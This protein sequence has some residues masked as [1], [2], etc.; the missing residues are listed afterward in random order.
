MLYS[1]LKLYRPVPSMLIPAVPQG[2][3]VCLGFFGENVNFLDVYRRLGIKTS[4]VKYVFEP[5]ITGVAS[6]RLT[7]EYKKTLR[8][9]KLLPVTGP[10]GDYSDLD[11]K[12]FFLDY[13]YPLQRVL[14]RYQ[15][16]NYR[17]PVSARRVLPLLN[18]LVGVP[19]S[20][21]E[22]V[23]L[24][25]VSIDETISPI[26]MKR[27][28]YIIYQLLMEWF[29]NPSSVKLP[30]DK[31]VMFMY[32][33]TE[34]GRYVLIFDKDSKLNKLARIKAILMNM[35]MED[36][37][38]EE[39]LAI[40]D[41]SQDVSQNNTLLDT[42]DD[43]MVDKTRRIVQTFINNSPSLSGFSDTKPPD[44][45][46]QGMD[47]S[48]TPEA[49]KKKNVLLTTAILSHTMGDPHKASKVAKRMEAMTTTDQSKIVSNALTYAL[50]RYDS[51]SSSRNPV[52]TMSNP[53]KMTDN[54]NPEHIL[55]KRKTDFKETLTD[56]LLD[57]FK[58]LKTKHLPLQV[59]S[60]K[61]TTVSSPPSE[62]KPTLKDR[63]AVKLTDYEN[64]VHDVLVELPHLTENGTFIVNGQQ[65]VLIN[66]L[67]VYP[68]FF[69]KP[70]SGKFT[71]SYSTV[72]IYSKILRK[73]SYLMLFM[74][75][76]KCPL[77]MY[78]SYRE[79]FEYTLKR[80][81]VE[82][83]ITEEKVDSS[84]L[85]PN[86]KY[87]SFTAKDE[88]GQQLAASFF[89]S[90]ASL[91]KEHF[92][93][94][95][96]KYWKSVLETFVGNRNCTYL[97][98]QVWQN[99]VTPIEI[100]L[101]ESRGDPTNI[102]DI[103]KYISGQV[104]HGR[105]DDRNTL[106]RQ[107]IR[108]S[109]IFVS[110][111]QKQ[112]LAAYNEYEAKREA[113]DKN[114]RLYINSTKTFSEVINSQNVQSLENINP[115]EELSS[116]TRVTPI[117]VGGIPNVEAYP[118]RAL[119][120]H[121]TYFGNIDP[122]ETPDGPNVGVQQQLAIG[123]N[124]T[125]VRG[126]FMHRDRSKIKPTEMLSTGPSMIP[127]V[128]SNEGARVTMATGQAKQAVP[129]QNP[130]V[131]C[132]QSGYESILTPLLSDAF[133][134]KAD[135]TGTIVEIND[136]II[137][138]EDSETK[139]RHAI[140]VT[141]ITLKSGQ[142]KNGLSAFKPIVSLG[143]KV[144]KGQV[145]AEGAN[146]KDGLISNGLN[147]LVA[148]MP[149]KGY[150][151]EDGMVISESAA[152]KFVSLHVE[153]QTVL[154]EEGEDVVFIAPT[155]TEIAKGSILVAYSS[156]IHDVESHK[157]LRSDGG[158]VVEVEVYSNLPEEQIPEK[159][160]PIYEDFKNRYIK[161]KGSYPIGQF[162]EKD[163]KIK[164]ILI[165]YTMQQALSLA[166]GDKLN[167]RHFNKGVVSIIEKDENMPRTPWG[168]HV[169]MVY[170]PL[171]VINRMI[172]GQILETHC[173]LIAKKLGEIITTKSRPEF[174]SLL[175]TVIDLLDGTPG[176]VYS[177]SLTKNILALSDKGYNNLIEKTKKDKFFPLIFVPFKSP[178]RN[179]IEKALSLCGLKPR[180]P[181]YLKEFDITTGP[182]AV[183]YV[184][185]LK[186]EHMSE[187]KIHARGVGPYM[188]G[189]MAPT[190]GKKRSGG[191]QLGEY[192]MYSLLGWDCPT[193]VDEFFGPSSSDH[194][195]KNQ[196]ISE[197]I[198]TG[199][200]TFRQ[201]KTNPVKDLFTHTMLAIHL[202][203]D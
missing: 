146:I 69:F 178:E 40:D 75:G 67:I 124:I 107:R 90:L 5:M 77:I 89:Y 102:S 187:K 52:T 165:K 20:N 99:V 172:T 110:L 73:A 31:I 36:Y 58:V 34:P 149:W 78:L 156:A 119:N 97:M 151:F 185:V 189:T 129:L 152:K 182:V 121:D 3:N 13:T 70:Y 174:E 87:I 150:N 63:Y 127:F 136:K 60:L 18:T 81:G 39:K 190:S 33:S 170:N 50:P 74:C 114:A 139:E 85:L 43:K 8:N 55:E 118:T 202:V 21:F 94:T 132:V 6:S 198:Q 138:I 92:D 191:Q 80:Y 106:D 168:E 155:G 30:F 47:A 141:P 195:T 83:S 108:T 131:P 2:K 173:G 199:E 128:E 158:K 51:Q 10:F 57:A 26:I 176:K 100:R 103:V 122:L 196:L 111:L 197:I 79:G 65:K 104:V 116:M 200:G 177:K 28:F 44:H 123:A 96:Q 88:L 24:Y 56:D 86:G 84:L 163:V 61:I 82:Y 22:R 98:D 193:L 120:T 49:Q 45:L 192:D 46:S 143:D 162:K 130:E 93:L 203:S 59:T 11:G 15:I 117:G 7:P 1:Q 29:K 101:L 16:T 145:L 109:E 144:R 37:G 154:L 32:Q 64:N 53:I 169:E 105:V 126:T 76:V 142:G 9:H 175:A 125:N 159:L 171:G 134:K 186:L 133:I 161:L 62:L 135:V 164:G 19:E 35:R 137:V 201:G 41:A 140:D 42:S 91:P 38:Q 184:Y 14:S 166:K 194:T 180:Y 72:T 12:N 148:F 160:F 66:Q 17:S 112:I 188:E 25:S 23:L 113:G 27:K 167:N 54:I 4:S 71:S 95:S 179:N 153:E 147:I 48:E 183:G 68:I 181:L 157:H 115:L